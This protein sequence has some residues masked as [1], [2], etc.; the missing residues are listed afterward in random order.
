M[1]EFPVI[2]SRPT[3]PCMERKLAAILAADVA[4]Y[5]ALMEVDEAG[6]FERLRAGRKELFEPE[7]SKHHGRI[8]KLMGDGLHSRANGKGLLMRLARSR[9]LPRGES[10]DYIMHA[11]KHLFSAGVVKK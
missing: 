6:T 3:R 7:V 5:S 2:A 1:I 8:F 9:P 10:R 11:M 4:G